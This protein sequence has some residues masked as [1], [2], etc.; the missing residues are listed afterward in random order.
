MASE[1]INV[2]AEPAEGANLFHRRL[3]SRIHCFEQ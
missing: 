1:A 3:T 2:G